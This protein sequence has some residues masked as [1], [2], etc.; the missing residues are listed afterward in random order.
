MA[1]NFPNNGSNMYI[2]IQDERSV[3]KQN[4]NKEDYTETQYKQFF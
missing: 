4:Q 3:P 2:Q 1:K